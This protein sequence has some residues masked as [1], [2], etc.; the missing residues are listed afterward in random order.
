MAQFLDMNQPSD[1]ESIYRRKAGLYTEQVYVIPLVLHQSATAIHLVTVCWK[2][3]TPKHFKV[4]WTVSEL[5]SIPQGIIMVPLLCTYGGFVI[6][7][8]ACKRFTAGS[9]DLPGSHFS[10]SQHITGMDI[11]SNCQQQAL[12]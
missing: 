8:L 3:G 10:D 11:L 6:K 5:T 7:S 12:L 4:C 9:M 2:R 1:L